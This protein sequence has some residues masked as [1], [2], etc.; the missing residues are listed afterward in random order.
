MNFRSLPGDLELLS[1]HLQNVEWS[2]NSLLNLSKP[3]PEN[4]LKYPKASKKISRVGFIV[5][6]FALLPGI[7]LR[8]C[9]GLLLSVLTPWE[10]WKSPKKQIKKFD[11][12]I[13]SNTSNLRSPASVD[14]VMAPFAS[15]IESKIAYLYLNAELTS[16]RGKKR[17]PDFDA[18][19]NL[20][21]CPKTENPISTLRQSIKSLV[22]ISEA[23]S[24]MAK[25]TETTLQQKFLLLNVMRAQFSRE[26]M[27]NLLIGKEVS[28]IAKEISARH[29]IYSFEGNAHELSILSRLKSNANGVEMLPYQHA[30][31]VTTQFGL[32][33]QMQ[34]FNDNTI[35]LTS[36]SITKDYFQTLQK[37]SSFQHA[38][39]EAGSYKF[40][41]ETLNFQSVEPE[42]KEVVLF[43]P[44]AD[45]KS[46]L[47]SLEIMKSLACDY[48]DVTF[49]I[50]KHPSLKLTK[51]LTRKI[52]SSLSTNCSLSS[53][54]LTED[55]KRS[56]V[57]V[58]RS[59]AAAI[60]AARFGVYPVHIDFRGEFN[61][62][63]FD[64]NFFKTGI[65]K[66]N[67]CEELKELI[68]L[69]FSKKLEKS[70]EYNDQLRD[71]AESYFSDPLNSNF[72]KYLTERRIN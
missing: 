25:N 53:L 52:V 63:P 44:E 43:L 35:I 2:A 30:P 21:I 32:Q 13:I 41:H 8:I 36:G 19:E 72:R 62:N 33:R 42:K 29:L 14:S 68:G 70:G 9:A 10:W 7:V 46:F 3:T 39:L 64:S 54:T 20:F 34:Q 28:R 51:R 66:A 57:C 17:F 61:L 23:I 49:V 4:L 67:T 11:W 6:A 5:Q 69:M 60:E 27:R 50:R 22:A 56:M 40:N 31:I 71:F 12:L 37:S 24:L 26:T 55:F 47:E 16:F 45:I 1:V 58:F 59:S 48:E 38:I 65:Q 15:V 18:H